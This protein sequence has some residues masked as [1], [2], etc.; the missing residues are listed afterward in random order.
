MRVL[1]SEEENRKFLKKKKKHVPKSCHKLRT[2]CYHQ[3]VLK[4]K[5]SN[6][7]KIKLWNDTS[8]LDGAKYNTI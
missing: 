3:L 2:V 6:S 8:T 7:Y 1:F 4:S 5:A